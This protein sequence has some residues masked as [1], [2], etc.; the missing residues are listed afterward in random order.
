MRYLRKFNENKQSIEEDIDHIE[1]LCRRYNIKNYTINEDMSVDVDGSVNLY[2]C[3]LSK[4]PLKFGY[5]SGSF[6][7]DHNQLETLEGSPKIVDYDFNCDNNQL[8]SLKGSPDY[9]IIS[10]H[11]LFILFVL[12]FIL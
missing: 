10:F 3:S 12:I 8:K 1:Y 11:N 9:F 4:I 5:V 6:R 2:R 7:C